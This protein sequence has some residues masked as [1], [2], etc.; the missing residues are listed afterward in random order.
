MDAEES[1]AKKG[2][3]EGRGSRSKRRSSREPELRNADNHYRVQKV[4]SP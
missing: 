1:L 2:S 4:W 3:E